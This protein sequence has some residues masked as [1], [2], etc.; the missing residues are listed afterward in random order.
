MTF[1]EWWEGYSKPEHFNEPLETLR[2]EDHDNPNFDNLI[3]GVAKMTWDAAAD[4]A[5]RRGYRLGLATDRDPQEVKQI[6]KRDI[7]ANRRI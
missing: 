5:F 1:D 4:D 6:E 2:H 3:E 7:N